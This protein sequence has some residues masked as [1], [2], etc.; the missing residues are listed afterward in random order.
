MPSTRNLLPRVRLIGAPMSTVS[1]CESSSK[2][3]S[4][5]SALPLV[6]LDPAPRPLKG[7]AGRGHGAVDVLRVALGDGCEQFAGCRIM[8]LEPLTGSR[9][10]P[11]AV[12]Q[13]L[14]VGTIR[15]RMARNRNC[16]CD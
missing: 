4:T 6:R 7:A 10:D 5:R 15:I 12:N 8:R 11:L 3:F 9:V 14:L 1:S 2:F 16:L 13:H